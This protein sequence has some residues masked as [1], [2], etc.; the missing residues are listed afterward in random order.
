MDRDNYNKIFNNGLAHINSAKILA[1]NN[2]YGFAISHLILSIEELIKY[3][4]VMTHNV[5]NTLFDKEAN[6]Q[7]G[8]SVFRDHLTKHDL[9]R[10]FQQSI[11]GGFSEKFIGSVFHKATG[12]PL[13]PEHIDVQTNRFKETGNFLNVAYKE[14]NIPEDERQ[15]FFDWLGKANEKKNKG[16]YVNP[17]NG[18]YESPSEIIKDEYVTAFKYADAILKQT[19]VIKSLDITEDEFIAFMNMEVDV[20]LPKSDIPSPSN[21]ANNEKSS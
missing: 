8:K 16:F 4:V 3:Q 9:I 6:P 1:D 15:D 12:Q 18:I 21:E 14:I 13:K 10:E 17:N 7:K 19:E 5:D 11:S 2:S 20:Q